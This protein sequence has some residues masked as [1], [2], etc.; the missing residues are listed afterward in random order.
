VKRGIWEGLAGVG[1]GREKFCSHI[2]ISKEKKRKEE[3]RREEKR[4]EKERKEKK[5]KEKK[6]KEKKR[7]E[8]KRKEKKR[9]EKKRKKTEIR[10]LGTYVLTLSNW[11]SGSKFWQHVMITWDIKN[12]TLED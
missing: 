9:K 8:K 11:T 5:R 10:G 2:I 3:K 1:N 4:K 7:K 12:N 6:R